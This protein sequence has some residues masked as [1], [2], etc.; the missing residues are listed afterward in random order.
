[1]SNSTQCVLFSF[2]L[3]ASSLNCRVLAFKELLNSKTSQ[4]FLLLSFRSQVTYCK[5]IS[6]TKG[7]LAAQ[8]Y[9]IVHVTVT[10]FI[11]LTIAWGTFLHL[12]LML[13]KSAL[14]SATKYRA[15]PLMYPLRMCAFTAFFLGICWLPN[16]FFFLLS[17]FDVTQLDTPVHHVTVVLSMFNSCMNPWIYGATNKKYRNEFKKILFFWKRNR[18]EHSETNV[19]SEMTLQ[20]VVNRKFSRVNGGRANAVTP[21]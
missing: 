5:W 17:K 7:K 19:I 10:F 8:I 2:R 4:I 15:R 18:V 20:N 14:N 16:Q 9:V 11:P 21:A 13:K 6:L 12:W 1:M 3:R